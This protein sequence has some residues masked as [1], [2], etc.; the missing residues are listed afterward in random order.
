MEVAQIAKSIAIRLNHTEP[1][2]LAENN[3]LDVDLIEFAGLC[4][5]IGHPPFGHTGE[6]AL[7]EHMREHGGFEGNAQTIRILSRLEKRQ[8]GNACIH[9]SG[10]ADDGK[11]MRAGLN[12]TARSL[13]AILKYDREIPRTQ[14]PGAK[15]AKGYYFQEKELVGWIKNSVLGIEAVCDSFKTVECQIMDLADDIAYSTYDLEDA[16]KHDF[17]SP[18]ELIS[19]PDDI[20]DE[21]ARRVGDAGAGPINRG[22]IREIIREVFATLLEIDSDVNP[23]T[24]DEEKQWVQAMILGRGSKAL[25]HDGYLRT[26]LTSALVGEFI[27]SI[28]LTPN[29]RFPSLSTVA[30]LGSVRTKVEVLKNVSFVCLIMSPRLRMSH[31]RGQRIVGEIFEILHSDDGARLMPEDFRAL[32]QRVSEQDR[33]RV[34]CDFIAGMT[35]RYAIEFYGRLTSKAPATIFK[36]L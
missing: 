33:P 24:S 2:L 14:G 16:L 11:D 19:L 22:N 6:D 17:F 28:V 29:A 25:A 15:V 8:K 36:P 35:D 3:K 21:V 10:I 26:G 23:V 30:L 27:R 34:V 4:H 9:S 5:D 7:N 20:L 31:Y 13:A 1:F 12:L 32:W 18:I